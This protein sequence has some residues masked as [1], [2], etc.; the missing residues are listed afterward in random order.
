MSR[1]FFSLPLP[2]HSGRSVKL[3]PLPVSSPPCSS[4]PLPSTPHPLSLPPLPPPPRDFSAGWREEKGV[5]KEESSNLEKPGN[6][7]G[8]AARSS[9]PSPLQPGFCPAA[10]AHRD[11]S[12]SLSLSLPLSLSSS[13]GRWKGGRRGS[14]SVPCTMDDDAPSLLHVRPF[15]HGLGEYYST[16]KR[17]GRG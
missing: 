11:L 2:S 10:A 14:H 6:G 1:P 5:P 15:C 4:I 16:T 3:L 17:G 9:L 7:G 8:E 12:L 13:D